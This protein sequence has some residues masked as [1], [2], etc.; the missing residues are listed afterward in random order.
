[1]DKSRIESGHALSGQFRSPHP[2]PR[3]LT[4]LELIEVLLE[5]TLLHTSVCYSQMRGCSACELPAKLRSLRRKY[6][7][8]S[9]TS[10]ARESL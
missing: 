5:T 1:M 6:S 3:R 10:T 8:F 9:R 4:F 7:D 2:T